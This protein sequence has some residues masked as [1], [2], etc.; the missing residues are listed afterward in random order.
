MKKKTIFR[1]IVENTN[2]ILISL[3]IKKKTHVVIEKQ[4]SFLYF[5][6]FRTHFMQFSASVLLNIKLLTCLLFSFHITKQTLLAPQ[7]CSIC[8]I[9]L[10]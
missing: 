6:G 1:N 2:I 3:F 7:Q 4:L 9:V 10:D 5:D 8:V